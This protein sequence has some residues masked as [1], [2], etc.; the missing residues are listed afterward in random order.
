MGAALYVTD[1]DGTLIRDD[2]TL[3]AWARR[4]LVAMLDEGVPITVATARSIASL[5]AILGD[6]PFRLPVVE[7]NGAFLTDYRTKKHDHVNAIEPGVAEE[8]CRLVMCS[9]MQPFLSAWDG[10]RDLLYY[11]GITNEGENAYYRER[12]ALKDDR[13]R[14][15]DDLSIGLRQQVVCLTLIARERELADLGSAISARFGTALRVT[16]YAFRYFP[17]WHFLS[18]HDRRATK[19]NGIKALQKTHGYDGVPLVVFGDDVNDMGMFRAAAH[20]VAM[21]NARP[22]LKALAHETIGTN[23]EDS[24][25]RWLRGKGAWR[26]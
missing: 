26:P 7:F 13:L 21:A 23:Q 10:S 12:L 14:L 17:G 2:L 18:I 25:I 20:A 11:R 24:V 1:L 19:E 9:G 6:I 5:S 4:E 3:S 16:I 15:V 8:A 22:E